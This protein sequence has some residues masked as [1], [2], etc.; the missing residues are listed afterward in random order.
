MAESAEH[1]KK[2]RAEVKE[3]VEKA[4]KWVPAR[5]AIFKDPQATPA[6]PL[7]GKFSVRAA[8][9]LY[10]EEPRAASFDIW[11]ESCGER[12]HCALP[13]PEY[14]ADLFPPGKRH[15]VAELTKRVYERSRKWFGRSG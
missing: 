11:C 3:A 6:C 14:A 1:D 4:W 10:C 12:H 5:E 2:R 7:C 8:W 15:V 9:G 13:L